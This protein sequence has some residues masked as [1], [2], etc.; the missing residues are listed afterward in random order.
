MNDPKKFTLFAALAL[1]LLIA[2]VT[3]QA[4]ELYS[5]GFFSSF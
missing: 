5:D 1:L 3:F 4:I 2:V